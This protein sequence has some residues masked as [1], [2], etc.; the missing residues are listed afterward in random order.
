MT[1]VGGE[2]SNP[3]RIN[4]GLPQGSILGPLWFLTYIEDIGNNLT[5]KTHLFA[6]DT[7]L[8]CSGIRHSQVNLT[9]NDDLVDVL[10]WS[11]QWFLP[12]NLPKCVS[13]CFSK[14]PLPG[15]LMIADHVLDR[16]GEHKHLGV[17]FTSSLS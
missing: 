14:K 9:L 16:V 8:Y 5:S 12:L 6:D 4:C 17:Y 1:M 15:L 13:M 11:I 7:L 3:I 10:Q 2:Q